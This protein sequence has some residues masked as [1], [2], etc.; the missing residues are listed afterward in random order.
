MQAGSNSGTADEMGRC[1]CS[2]G[3]VCT[4]QFNGGFTARKGLVCYTHITGRR[5]LLDSLAPSCSTHKN[6]A[7]TTSCVRQWPRR[8]RLYY[9]TYTKTYSN[10]FLNGIKTLLRLT[11]VLRRP[12][13]K[14]F[15]LL[16]RS[17]TDCVQPGA[18]HSTGMCGR[19]KCSHVAWSC[20]GRRMFQKPCFQTHGKS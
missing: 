14:Q 17:T 19:S 2:P 9:K 7:R 4:S 20:P 18:R 10:F 8:A 12:G 3:T 1:V 5:T 13:K 6:F 15:R 11:R 16:N